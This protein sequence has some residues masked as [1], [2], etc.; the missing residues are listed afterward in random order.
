ME[1]FAVGLIRRHQEVGGVGLGPQSFVES[2]SDRTV[3]AFVPR[4]HPDVLCAVKKACLVYAHKVSLHV[5]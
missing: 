3:E 5:D 1:S 2:A 4:Q